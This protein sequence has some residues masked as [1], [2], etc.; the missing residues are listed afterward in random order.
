MR[1]LAIIVALVSSFCGR[2]ASADCGPPERFAAAVR[3]ARVVLIDVA[4]TDDHYSA[5]IRV[6]D[7]LKGPLEPRSLELRF[8][9]LGGTSLRRGKRYLAFFDGTDAFVGSCATMQVVSTDTSVQVLRKFLAAGTDAERIA[10][11]VRAG[12]VAHEEIA[13][14]ALAYLGSRPDL[15]AQVDHAGTSTL[16]AAIAHSVGPHSDALAWVLARLHVL[17]SVP[18]WIEWQ[19]AMKGGQNGRPVQ[20][21]LELMTNHRDPE[22]H[23]GRDFDGEVHAR[24]RASW[25]AWWA[26][27]RTHPLATVLTDGQ[28]ERGQPPLMLGDATALRHVVET[29]TDLLSIAEAL[30]ACERLRRAPTTRLT[31]YL[32]LD[33]RAESAKACDAPR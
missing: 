19:R 29:S 13:T 20:D 7:A 26:A 11:I 9:P 14:E 4:S 31:P 17:S 12:T 25:Q 33:D 16:V 28:R 8:N 22:Y 15:L 18:A 6:V 23:P 3:A 10:L 32:A 24:L 30:D 2:S 1:A 21:A 5:S 27:N